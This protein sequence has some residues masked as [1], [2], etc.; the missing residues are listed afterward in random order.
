M[1]SVGG[2]YSLVLSVILF[3]IFLYLPIVLLILFS[4]NND[5]YIFH[6]QGFTT[7]WYR[8]LLHSTE[9]RYAFQNSLLVAIT[10]TILSL[11]LGT[12]FV[13]YASRTLTVR[14]QPLFYTI[15]TIPEI[16]VAVSML[17]FLGYLQ[18]P[19][20]LT[21]LIVGHTL[22]GLGYI[23]PMVYDRFSDLDSRVI[24]AAY[25]LGAT[26][27]Q[28]VRT[29]IIP[30]LR[31]ALFSAG[32]LVFIISLD[33]FV[34]SFFCAGG[35][36]QTLPMYIFAMIKSGASPVVAALA[37]VMLLFSS[38]LVCIFSLFNK[39]KIEMVRR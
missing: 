14:L 3:Y 16:M 25:D 26:R 34:L 6:W 4:F 29:I 24:E 31:P 27:S 20:G 36:T 2:T 32:I 5:P 37:T 13:C 1:K 28:V 9:I 12:L 23:V 33:D 30:L 35:T 7:Q 38:L 21:T 15:L 19:L 22:L 11:L 18:I 39:H 8:V 10:S 17:I